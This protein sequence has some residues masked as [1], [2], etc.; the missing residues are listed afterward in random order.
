MVFPDDFD[1]DPSED[2]EEDLEDRADWLDEVEDEYIAQGDVTV[3]ETV[4]GHDPTPDLDDEDIF[5]NTFDEAMH[6]EDLD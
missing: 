4:D 1:G 2:R 6:E 3:S 5:E